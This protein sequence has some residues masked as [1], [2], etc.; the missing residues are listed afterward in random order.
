MDWERLRKILGLFAMIFS[1]NET[2]LYFIIVNENES[3]WKGYFCLLLL[4]SPDLLTL[5]N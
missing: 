1:G 4:D 3:G 2:V 5:N